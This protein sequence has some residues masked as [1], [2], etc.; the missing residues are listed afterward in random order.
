LSAGRFVSEATTK[1]MVFNMSL[2]GCIEAWL[3]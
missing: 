3:I 1:A 2:C